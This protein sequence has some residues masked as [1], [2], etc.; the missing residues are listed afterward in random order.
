MFGYAINGFYEFIKNPVD[1]DVDYSTFDDDE[2][3]YEIRVTLHGT[4]N[5][6]DTI[7]AL[8]QFH[9]STY[10]ELAGISMGFCFLSKAF[11]EDMTKS[12]CDLKLL[13][14]QICKEF[15]SN[16]LKNAV[17]ISKFRDEF[18]ALIMAIDDS[19]AEEESKPVKKD[20]GY[21]YT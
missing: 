19:D 17:D 2:N 5:G 1:Y 11:I 14:S 10:T 4:A 13:A 21:R 8:V 3:L 15:K 18:A 16:L 6:T 9:E 12:G 20:D 7:Y